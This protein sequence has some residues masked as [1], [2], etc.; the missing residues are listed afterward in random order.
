MCL[1]GVISGGSSQL[2]PVSFTASLLVHTC[3]GGQFNSS[4]HNC[5]HE[6]GGRTSTFQRIPQVCWD[7]IFIVIIIANFTRKQIIPVIRTVIK[8]HIELYLPF[9]FTRIMRKPLRGI[10]RAMLFCMGFHWVKVKGKL[11]TSEEAPI[12][13]VA[14]HSS[15]IDALALAVLCIPSSVSRE[16]NDSIPL[17]GGRLSFWL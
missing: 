6:K 8:L 10:A 16:E 5:L 11:S 1:P 9:L 7:N 15:F 4:A 17:I 13:T 2:N 3:F 12:L 14:P